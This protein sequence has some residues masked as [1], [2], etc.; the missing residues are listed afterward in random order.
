[1]DDPGEEGALLIHIATVHFGSPGWIDIQRRH[2]DAHVEA[3]FEVWT[4]LEGIDASYA[5]RFEH[6]LEQRGAHA[7][8]LNQLA[9]E[10]CDAAAPEDVIAFFDGDA[11]PIAPLAPAI[12]AALAEAPL[13]AV[14]RA[15]NGADR[16]PH[17]CFCATTV[18][19]WRKIGGDWGAAAPWRAAD[20]TGAPVTDVGGNLLRRLEQ[21][22]TPWTPLLRTNR[23]DIHPVFFAVYGDLVYH[24]GAGFRPAKTRVD[25]ER[26]QRLRVNLPS[27][28]LTTHVNRQLERGQ[29]F[30]IVRQN[31][32]RS[33]ALYARISAGDPGWLEELRGRA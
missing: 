2:F 27:R 26:A 17:P 31:A 24:H 6:V 12:E 30:R 18:A 5:S 33:R 16:Q 10:I 23:H 14:Q 1:M 20:G 21:T 7:G 32:Q 13:L 15:E 11:F 25:R 28:R 8:K 29:S 19:T 22:G 9:A 3:P 4:S